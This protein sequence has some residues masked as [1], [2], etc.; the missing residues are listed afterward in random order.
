MNEPSCLSLQKL[1]DVLIIFHAKFILALGIVRI[2]RGF[3][4]LGCLLSVF[5]ISILKYICT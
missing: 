2:W 5:I 1:L 4:I 3:Q